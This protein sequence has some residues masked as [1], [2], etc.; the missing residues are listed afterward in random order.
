[1][2]VSKERHVSNQEIE[3][4]ITVGKEKSKL[5]TREFSVNNLNNC[6][7]KMESKFNSRVPSLYGNSNGPA[8]KK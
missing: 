8:N 2:N 6:A 1:L 7:S 4:K 3:V 5:N